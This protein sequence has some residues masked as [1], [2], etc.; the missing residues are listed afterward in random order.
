MPI[1]LL[2]IIIVAV[3]V[4][5]ALVGFFIL[6]WGQTSA[7]ISA[8]AAR[9]S[10]CQRLIIDCTRSASTIKIDNFDADKDGS[11]DPGTTSTTDNLETLCS[12]YFG[13][14]ETDCKESCGC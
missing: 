1:N 2:I 9:A 3:I 7:G 8:E 12:E 5:I 4:L 14:S 10:A 13:L 6:G 11:L